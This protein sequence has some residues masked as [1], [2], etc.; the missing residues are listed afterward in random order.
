VGHMPQEDFPQDT[1]RHIKV[2]RCRLTQSK[3]KLK[4]PGSKHLKLKHNNLVSNLGFKFKL[5]RY[6]KGFFES[7]LKATALGSMRQGAWCP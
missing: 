5:G 3:P 2:R 6:I 4:A 7:E 1:A